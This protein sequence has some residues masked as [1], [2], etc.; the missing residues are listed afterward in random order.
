MLSF[1]G[2]PRSCIGYRFALIEY[3]THS[4]HLGL[5]SLIRMSR[6]G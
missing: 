1:L 6:L 3:A 4:L 5:Y 2:G